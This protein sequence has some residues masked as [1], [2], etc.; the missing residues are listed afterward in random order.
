ML[1]R[2]IIVAAIL[3][4]LCVPSLA[5]AASYPDGEYGTPPV[6][7]GEAPSTEMFVRGPEPEDEKP[8]ESPGNADTSA[9]WRA[10][11]PKTIDATLIVLPLVILLGAEFCAYLACAAREDEF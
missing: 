8:S 6:E 5:Y 3:M 2:S 4:A 9:P 7:T 1:R 11:L 10:N